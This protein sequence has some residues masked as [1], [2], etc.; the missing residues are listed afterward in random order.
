MIRVYTNELESPSVDYSLKNMD[1]VNKWI[2]P[3]EVDYASGEYFLT[4]PDDVLDQLHWQEGNML[5]FI[6]NKDGSFLVKKVN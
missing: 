6:D 3:V 5:Q 1:K 2:L 4:I